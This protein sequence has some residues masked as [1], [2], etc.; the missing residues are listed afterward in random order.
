MASFSGRRSYDWPSALRARKGFLHL[1]AN[2]GKLSDP[3]LPKGGALLLPTEVRGD[4][5]GRGSEWPGNTRKGRH[6]GLMTCQ[7]CGLGHVP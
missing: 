2:F 1:A 5:G 6:I 4:P 7:V 3:Q